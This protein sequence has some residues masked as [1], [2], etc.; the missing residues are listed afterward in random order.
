VYDVTHGLR[1][2][3]TIELDLAGCDD[4]LLEKYGGRIRQREL[5][6]RAQGAGNRFEQNRKKT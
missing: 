2:S 6:T 3:A 4:E 5:V 1:Q